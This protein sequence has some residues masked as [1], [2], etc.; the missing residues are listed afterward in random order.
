MEE[1]TENSI[2]KNS[3]LLARNTPV[4][5][6]VGAAGFLGSHIVDHLLKKG[7]QVIGVDNLETGKPKNL[8][9][10]VKDKHFH[11][12]Q[13][14]AAALDI[15]L[16][17]L[18]YVFL[19]TGTGWK[20]LSFL[21]WVQSFHP[22][23]AFVSTINLYDKEADN[24]LL[25]LKNAESEFAKFA[26]DNQLNARVIRLAALY[27]PR[28]HFRV[29][30]PIVRLIKSAIRGDLQ[31]EST[32]L[33]FSTRA[34]FIDDAVGL[35]IKSILAGATALKIFDGVLSPP[36]KVEDIKQVL[37]DPLWY[38]NRGFTPT[39]L[40]PW[41]TPNLEKTQ[42]QLSWHPKAQLVSSLKET[43]SYFKENEIEITED[44]KTQQIALPEEPEIK[45]G[46]SV[47]NDERAA[48]L[49]AFR[50]QTPP[51]IKK[52]ANIEEREV[53]KVEKE[54]S[55]HTNHLYKGLSVVVLILIMYALILPIITAGYGIYLF[56]TGLLSAADQLGKGEIEQSIRSVESAEQGIA[57]ITELLAPLDFLR[58]QQMVGEYIYP[59]Y[60]LR[61]LAT[62]IN[63]SVKH[64]ILGTQAIYA[65]LKSITG[66][67]N[68]DT[69]ANLQKAQSELA[70]AD[71][72]LSKASAK[73]KDDQFRKR[74]PGMVRSRLAPLENKLSYYNNLVQ[75]GRAGTTILTAMV[76]LEGKKKYLVLLQNNSELR[77]TGGFIG[78]FA[79]IDFE[80]G[81]LKNLQVNDIY[82]IDGQLSFH[83]EPPK[84]L[85]EDLGQNDWYLRDSNW[86][87]D[88]ATAARQAEWF[89]VRETGNRV[90]GVIALDIS[91]VENL[92]TVVGELDLA[93][94]GEKVNAQNLFEQAVTHAEQG[95][96]PG[97]Q[98]KK[99]FLTA[100]VNQL[101]NKV[102]FLPKQDWPGIV[103][104]MGKSLEEKHL[105]VYL[106]D[107]KL[108]SYMVS[109]NW[110]GTLPR[111]TEEVDGQV[112]DFL[113][114][115]EAN[116]GANKANYYVDR[117]YEL[118]TVIGKEGEVDHRLKVSYTNRS[119]SNVW[120]AG[121][122]KDRMR[123]Y[124]PF[125]A[126]LTK[127]V[128]GEQDITKSVTAFADYGRTGYSMLLELQPKE[129]KGLIFTYRLPK[130]VKF[131]GADLL[132]QLDIIKQ[133][134]TLEDP[135]EWKLAYPIN[136]KIT[137]APSAEIAPQEYVVSTDL[138]RDRR[139]E[140]KFNK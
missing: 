34:L 115:F 99:Q 131:K 60:D 82:E 81:K 45:Q 52:A 134:G 36:T 41:P 8:E 43:I 49:S 90:D 117:D 27:G 47:D 6:V 9:K 63:Q 2:K 80:G 98:A 121:K 16:A 139:L 91:A 129:S 31:K 77:P 55:S 125:G 73:L 93:D 22:R 32:V 29:N 57:Y 48:L 118:Q 56:R 132:Y 30:D 38:E 15:E 54:A 114:I 40:P 103:A 42:K 25:W 17:R 108:F 28:M 85:K 135:F 96:F 128:W 5:L 20:L 88:F 79:Q 138:S 95:F 46:K 14:A 53:Q 64:S 58:D 133:P 68:D 136:Y 130:N 92:L 124:L 111:A 127:V 120:P 72:M 119:P 18:D 26:H 35:I 13:T 67:T 59:L 97:S 84:E 112:N 109:Q 76:A 4:A 70:E 86:E 116:L 51:V 106:A 74:T 107:Q 89:Y 10:A 1:N 3:I 69:A 122:Y 50:E 39:E 65:S 87:P 44:D 12:I 126:T 75:K 37:L 23:I 24:E 71:K 105:M 66:E 137:S 140:V 113:A 33:E 21:K 94:Y 110:A 78:S 61:D 104:A 7:I 83:V 102:F 123:I 101:F 62:Y 19:A 100:L 11:F